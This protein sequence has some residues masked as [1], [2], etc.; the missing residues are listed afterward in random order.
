MQKIYITLLATFLM[1]L[2]GCAS[3]T[4]DI[5]VDAESDP[6]ANLSGYKTYTWLGAGEV[7]NDP[8]KKWKQTD[9]PIAGNIKYL[10]EREL[11]KHG[12][13]RAKP[14]NADLGVAFFVGIDMEAQKLKKNPETEVEMIENVP[15]AGLIIALVDT[16]SGF[17]VWVGEAVGELSENATDEV[18]E[19]RI[20][21]AVTEMFKLLDNK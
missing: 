15:E 6:K 3:V 8:E 16:K 1:L 9:L 7:L 4:S 5:K 18:V 12:I 17:V 10:I 19:E 13:N 2:T 14:A 21:F 11:L 20:D